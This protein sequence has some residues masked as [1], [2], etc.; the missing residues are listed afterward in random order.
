MYPRR[1]VALIHTNVCSTCIH[2][3][4]IFSLN[5]HEAFI[6]AVLTLVGMETDHHMIVIC[7]GARSLARSLLRCWFQ[8][9]A[10]GALCVCCVGIICVFC[11][12]VF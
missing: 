10:L 4:D 1:V 11:V 5:V 3:A 8:A 12:R 7:I 6:S 2:T 9:K